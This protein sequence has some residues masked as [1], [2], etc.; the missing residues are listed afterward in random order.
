MRFKSITLI[1]LCSI[2][3]ATNLF[4]Q[5]MYK[6]TG[7]GIR[8]AIWKP[9]DPGSSIDVGAYPITILSGSGEGG[10]IYFFTRLKDRW[11]LEMSIGGL[12]NLVL[13][14]VGTRGTYT[15]SSNIVPFLFGARYDWLSPEYGSIFQPYLSFG[16]GL[17]WVNRTKNSV[18]N[19]I[20]ISSDTDVK[21]GFYGGIGLNVP[22]ASWFALNTDIKVHLLDFNPSEDYSG[23]E[24]GFGFSFMWGSNPEIFRVEEVKV[25]V[26]DIYPAYYQFYNS[27][28]LALVMV[29]NMVSYPI[30][31][32]IYSDIKG[33]SERS[34]ESGFIKINPGETKDIPVYALFGPKLLYATQREPAVIDLELE[35]RA[36]ATHTKTIS[37][38]VIIHSRNAWNG[39]IDRLGFFITPDN[40]KVMEISR[41]VVGQNPDSNPE[42]IKNFTTAKSL[43]DELK[44]MGIRYQSDPNIPFYQD[45]YVQFAIETKE[46]GVGDCDDLVVLYASLLE[47]VGINT[48]FVQVKDPHKEI[49]HLYLLFDSGSS[50]GEGHLISSNEKRYLIREKSS[51]KKSLWIPIETTLVEEGF[52]QAWKT[53][54]MTYLE[55]GILRAGISEGWVRIIDVD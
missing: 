42:S 32:N 25:I 51:G 46:K 55:E 47:S 53:G 54:A 30:E 44:K 50:P 29:K 20:D 24:Y 39:E 31:V 12:G 34:Q 1:T 8:S 11:Y 17:H 22:L 35:A 48:A 27:Y 2:F 10:L 45:D 49:A 23:V 13:T 40:E 21:T 9:T 14:K 15:G 18:T 38:N 19:Q 6:S 41:N 28:P 33:Y 52:E 43:F 37:V 26:Q 5:G 16:G 3:I 36:G 7:I 4:A